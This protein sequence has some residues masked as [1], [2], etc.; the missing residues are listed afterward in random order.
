MTA[1][2]RLY[3]ALYIRDGINPT[4]T[5]IDR[6]HWALLTLPNDTQAKA[7]RFHARDFY[8][9]PEETHWIYE[10]LHVSAAGTPKLLSQIFIGDIVD[11]ERF[12]EI[13]RDVRV[14]QEEGWN[15]VAWV[16]EAVR[17]VRG[18]DVLGDGDGDEN[19][20]VWEVVKARALESA[21]WETVKRRERV[22]ALL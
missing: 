3:L 6:H 14:R 10:E 16:E 9:S 19:E 5:G 2:L 20:E 1:P 15:C 18:Q 12:V 8:T 11:E 7:T 13:V 22:R 21:D 17:G 4:Y